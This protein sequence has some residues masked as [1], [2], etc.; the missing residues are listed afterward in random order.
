MAF[1]LGLLTVVLALNCLFLILL[2]LVQLPKKDAGAGTAFG[3][4]ATDALFGAGTGNALTKITKYAT[5][6][7]FALSLLLAI[8][9]SNRSHRSADEFRQAMKNQAGGVPVQQALPSMAS[10][11]LEKA[12]TSNA[13]AAKPV[14][15]NALLLSTPTTTNAAK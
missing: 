4:G 14:A 1:I 13:P 12:V 5:G 9:N 10:N 8:T 11:Q 3:G 6:T 2:I 7:F 15:T